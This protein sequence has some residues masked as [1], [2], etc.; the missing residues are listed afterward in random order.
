MSLSR[1]KGWTV[2]GP[3][4]APPKPPDPEFL[5]CVPIPQLLCAFL[6][7]VAP[8]TFLWTSF[9][10]LGLHVLQARRSQMLLDGALPRATS[11][12]TPLPQ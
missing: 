1:I 7:T 5:L 6:L 12:G 3:A 8:V 9:E 2:V 4:G 11:A 10:L